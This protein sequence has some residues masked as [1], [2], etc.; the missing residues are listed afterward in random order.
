ML[1]ALAGHLKMTVAEL[2]SRMDS[3][4]LSEWI[5]Y[6]RYFEALPD[7]WKQTAL[8]TAAALAP[9]CPKGKAPK[10][11]DFVPL[12]TPPQHEQQM[13]DQLRALKRDLEVLG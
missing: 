8:L 6:T 7:P 4:E 1:F 3:R 5:A 9:Y 2:C 13:L 11:E 10:V 12:D